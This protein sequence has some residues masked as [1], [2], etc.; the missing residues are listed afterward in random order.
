MMLTEETA[1]RLQVKD[2]LDARASIL[3]GARYLV[4]MRESLP[5]RIPEYEC[6]SDA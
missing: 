1:Q 5:P 4:I 2:R 6:A 3:G